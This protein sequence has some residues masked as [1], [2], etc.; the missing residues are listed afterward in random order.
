MIEPFAERGGWAALDV[1]TPGRSKEDEA[2]G[3][4]IASRFHECFRTEPGRF[5]LDRLINITILRPTVTPESTQFEAGIKEGRADI[6]RQIMA[7]IELAE[8]GID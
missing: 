1:D 2:K 3:R 5:V 8:R 4:E 7:N 6:V